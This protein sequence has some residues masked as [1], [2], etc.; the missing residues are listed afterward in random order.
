MTY[1]LQIFKD[2]PNPNYQKQLE[3]WENQNYYN[4]DI[5]IPEEFFQEKILECELT[6]EEYKAVK[7]ACLEVK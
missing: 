5:Q 3:K 6:D 7:K 1:K 4:R 2:R